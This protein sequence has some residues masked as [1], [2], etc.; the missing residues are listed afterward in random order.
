[1]PEKRGG[2]LI[3]A[4]QRGVE[5]AAG[6]L[7]SVAANSGNP[8]GPSLEGLPPHYGTRAAQQA[9]DSFLTWLQ[10]QA[11]GPA[12]FGGLGFAA[13]RSLGE[14]LSGFIFQDGSYSGRKSRWKD[15]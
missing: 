1:M 12:S 3:Q 6:Y 7:N 11:G 5:S 14:T 10:G 13:S 9:A 8:G 4:G 15:W 2:K